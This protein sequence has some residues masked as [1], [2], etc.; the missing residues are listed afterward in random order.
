MDQYFASRGFTGPITQSFP[1][2][3]SEILHLLN[4]YDRPPFTIQRVAEVLQRCWSQYRATHTIMN[5]LV[6][7]LSV[8]LAVSEY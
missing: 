3:K 7:L 4:Q 1:M 8:S 5:S 2:R 6:K